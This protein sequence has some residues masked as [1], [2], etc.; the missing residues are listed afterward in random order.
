[1]SENTSGAA[2]ARTESEIRGWLAERIAARIGVSPRSINPTRPFT[3]LGIDST[4]AVVLSGEL[5]EWLGRRVPPTAAWDHPTIELLAQ[6]LANPAAST[7]TEG[8]EG[9][10][11]AH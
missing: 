8:T 10:D 3:V 9:S 5:Q 2:R 7:P 11:P 6:H 4:E 1:M